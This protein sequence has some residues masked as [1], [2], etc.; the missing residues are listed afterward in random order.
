[1]SRTTEERLELQETLRLRELK[2]VE[3]HRAIF[4]KGSLLGDYGAVVADR[5]DRWA[6]VVAA[7]EVPDELGK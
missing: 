3:D 7:I 5:L 4:G 1:M 2:A 6:D